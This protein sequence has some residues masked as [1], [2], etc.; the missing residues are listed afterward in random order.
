MLPSPINFYRFLS[1]TLVMLLPGCAAL[2]DQSEFYRK[3]YMGIDN[4]GP[5]RSVATLPKVSGYEVSLGRIKQANGK[6]VG[7]DG[8]FE[9]KMGSRGICVYAFKVNSIT[10]RLVSW[11]LATR[12]T[13]EKCE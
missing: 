9:V 3:P 11:R 4:F 1:L 8:V 12:E 2:Q 5:E 13:P 6:Y 10:G 7:D